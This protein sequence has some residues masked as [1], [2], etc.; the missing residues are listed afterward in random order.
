MKTTSAFYSVLL[1]GL[2]CILI[3]S[4]SK[5]GTIKT[6]P[7]VSVSVVTNITASSASAGGMVSADGGSTVTSRGVC[8]STSQPPSTSNSKTSD[9][10][11]TGSFTSSIAGLSPGTTYYLMAYAINSLGTGYSSQS[12]FT[13]SALPPVITT[14]AITTI[15]ST[16]ASS[17]GTITSNGGS[18]ITASGVCW[19]TNQNPGIT[20]NKTTDGSATGSYTSSITG[21]T[22]G[23]NYYVRAYATNKAGT[24]YGNQLTF[25]TA[26]DLPPAP[27]VW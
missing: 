12:T 25:T 1:V 14:A 19:S 5:Q 26:Q 17:G 15:T 9:G 3:F 23:T 21:L 27:P 13:T 4:C 11:G 16:S 18:T 22:G 6:I 8:W 2:L 10:T 7:I 20:D 24:A